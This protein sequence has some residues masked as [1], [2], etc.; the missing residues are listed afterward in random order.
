MKITKV[1]IQN[2]K[3]IK[4]LTF[5]PS[6]RINVI[7]GENSVGKSNIFDAMTWPIGHTYP[8]FN[9]ILPEDHYDG[10]IDR[11]IKI[12]LAYDDGRSL[13]LAE[14]WT[15][16]RGNSKTGLNLSGNY[17]TDELRREYCSAFIGVDRSISDYL[18]SNRWSLLGRILLDINKR[19]SSEIIEHDDGTEEKKTD[20]LKSELQ[21]VRDD[22]LF[23]VK[24]DAGN[25]I[26][27]TFLETI[28]SEAAKQLNRS[29]DEFNLDLTLY[30][31]WNFYRSLQLLVQEEGKDL[32]FKAS[33]LGM[34]VQASI[35][36]AILKAYSQIKIGNNNPLFIDEPELF[37]HPH[38]QQSFYKLLCDLADN[39][40]QIFLTTHS[41]SFL[42]LGRFDE[43]F[44]AKKDTA[45]GTTLKHSS[46]YHFIGDF[47]ART[48]IRTT[49]EEF[50][51]RLRNA[52]ENTGDSR[53]ANEAFF[54]KK[55]L[56]VEGQTETL[57]LPYLF[58]LLEY[59]YTADGLSIVRCGEKG[60][61]DRFF[62][63]YNELG[64]PC[65]MLFDGDKHNQRTQAERDTI[66]KNRELLRL[67]GLSGDF[68]DGTVQ[69]KCLG[70][71]YDFGK[72]I[73]YTTSLKSLDLFKRIK[74]EMTTPESIPEWVSELIAKI[75]TLPS[76]T[77][78]CLLPR[79]PRT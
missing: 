5:Y 10:V 67:A 38:A 46:L 59:D 16:P 7:I 31:P 8:S 1:S 45:N 26:M 70:F 17:I 60:E 22:L 29:P 73:G 30:D 37:L 55:I 68:P 66:K 4:K 56:L 79:P 78:T 50:S 2:Y 41:P 58:N 64:I 74:A 6:P 34:G 43:I 53:R 44:I 72:S 75:R 77:S 47:E 32:R 54:A 9:A 69:E 33:S 12:H 52:F 25:N 51:L 24:D 20:K 62:R 71:E 3:S 28:K 15:D 63:V 61:I 21:K 19:F 40:T 11:K 65:F 48:N 76:V 49:E 36:I 57:A 13:E 27:K 14:E 35:T 42:S 18:P 23:S 39:G